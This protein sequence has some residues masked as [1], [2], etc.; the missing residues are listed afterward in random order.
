M[1]YV[2][3]VA[4]I[5]IKL[6]HMD[7]GENIMCKYFC[8]DFFNALVNSMFPPLNVHIFQPKQYSIPSPAALE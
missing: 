3:I 6:T 2:M 1:V 5:L 7:H 4:V 8:G